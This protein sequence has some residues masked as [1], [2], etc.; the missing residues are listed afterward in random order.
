MVSGGAR[1][2]QRGE[3]EAGNLPPLVDERIARCDS[4]RRDVSVSRLL[5]DYCV[6]VSYV[7]IGRAERAHLAAA[8]VERS[9]VAASWAS[10]LGRR[11]F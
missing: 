9:A 4:Y 10:A 6:V 5:E 3:N 8:I 7:N 1:L 2:D 11:W